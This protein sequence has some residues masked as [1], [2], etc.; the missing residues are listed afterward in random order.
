MEEGQ[1][2]FNQV[3]KSIHES[4]QEEIDEKAM[5]Y[6]RDAERLKK[7]RLKQMEAFDEIEAE[8]YR[9]AR[10]FFFMFT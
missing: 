6:L 3:Y 1:D 2:H 8:A 10:S 4:S 5:I 7:E 9:K